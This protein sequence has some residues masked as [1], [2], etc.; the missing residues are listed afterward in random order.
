MTTPELPPRLM[1]PPI[2]TFEPTFVKPEVCVEAVPPYCS[3]AET[4]RGLEPSSSLVT[5]DASPNTLEYLSSLCGIVLKQEKVE[6]PVKVE[7]QGPAKVLD[8]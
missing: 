7:D 1:P 8:F 6:V 5:P 2:Y 4:S 3:S